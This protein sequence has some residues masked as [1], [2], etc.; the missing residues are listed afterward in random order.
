VWNF[1]SALTKELV[2]TVAEHAAGNYRVATIMAA[3]LLMSGVAKGSQQ[4][5]KALFF[6]VFKAAKRKAKTQARPAQQ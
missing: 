2:G 1:T 3:D 6:D 5:D 4:L